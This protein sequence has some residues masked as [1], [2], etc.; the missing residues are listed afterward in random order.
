MPQS[1]VRR[2]SSRRRPFRGLLIPLLGILCTSMLSDVARAE[3]PPPKTATAEDMKNPDNW[4][5][6]PDYGYATGETSKTRK[7]GQ[8]ELYSFLPDRSPGAVYELR[9]EDTAAGMSVD[10]LA[11]IQLKKTGWAT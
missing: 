7:D 11:P 9:P 10:G 5:N 8:W 6:D 2:D 3:W 4:P 1:I